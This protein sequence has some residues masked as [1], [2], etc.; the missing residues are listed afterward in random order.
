METLNIVEIEQKIKNDLSQIRN[1]ADLLALQKWAK[2]AK[3]QNVIK[4]T[5]T[6]FKQL[7]YTYETTIRSSGSGKFIGRKTNWVDYTSFVFLGIEIR[8]PVQDKRYVFNEDEFA[9]HKIWIDRTIKY[10]GCEYFPKQPLVEYFGINLE[11]RFFDYLKEK[12]F[13][14]VKKNEKQYA[15]CNDERNAIKFMQGRRL[16]QFDLC[17]SPVVKLPKEHLDYL[18]LDVRDWDYFYPKDNSKSLMDFF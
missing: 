12:S 6:S 18:K 11:A 1:P 10:G 5:V 7:Y 17:N 16:T 2:K 13:F 14:I 8:L 4:P 15:L 9:S 3:K